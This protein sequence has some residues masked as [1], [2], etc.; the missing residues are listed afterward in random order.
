LT[1]THK[2]EEKSSLICKVCN[3]TLASKF[4]CLRHEAKCEEKKTV[5][6]LKSSQTN[7]PTP[8]IVYNITNHND[9][10][11]HNHN[12]VY[13]T[14][15]TSYN[16]HTNNNLKVYID[17]LQPLTDKTIA[18]VFK[19][20]FN[21][22]LANHVVLQE[23]ELTSKLTHSDLLNYLITSDASR[24]ITH[25]KD[26]DQDDKHIRDEYCKTL[27]NKI[28]NLSLHEQ[29]FFQEY[30]QFIENELERF[31]HNIQD[32]K[33]LQ[34]LLFTRKFFRKMA[35]SVHTL[36]D[37]GKLI[38]KTMKPALKDEHEKHKKL[39]EPSLSMV[40]EALRRS[41]NAQPYKYIMQEPE[42]LGNTLKEHLEEFIEDINETSISLK[43]DE[44][45]T[46][47]LK[48]DQFFKIVKDELKD[49]GCY[50]FSFK[51]FLSSS[52]IRTYKNYIESKEKAT[53]N[54][55]Q[56]KKWVEGTLENDEN[57][58]KRMLKYINMKVN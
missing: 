18:N 58:E 51:F 17:N 12:N 20:I 13:N 31:D 6:Q 2:D 27:A 36:E 21:T 47:M 34:K 49:E 10:S 15:N 44:K 5:E 19:E 7:Q 26:G 9:N 54:F 29:P 4:S 39:K 22:S 32:V 40:K 1:K 43:D 11:I 14:N 33:Y 48:Y 16:N 55:E 53:E 35:K 42:Y 37:V 24:G 25:W 52:N 30:L 3:K 28:Y 23:K 8:T 56:F 45:S 46:V 41:Y 57:F 50:D 38:S